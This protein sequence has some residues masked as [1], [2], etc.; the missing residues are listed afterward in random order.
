MHS[1]S[2]YT[3]KGKEINIRLRLAH[4][5]SN[6]WIKNNE[7]YILELPSS[8]ARFTGMSLGVI[9]R[10]M[11]DGA[12]PS[13]AIG[14]RRYVIS[15]ELAHSREER[16]VIDFSQQRDKVKADVDDEH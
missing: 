5:D 9:G 12:L 1:S 13:M 4:G 7:T 3:F 15:P 11:D 10:L 2:N 16:P 6:P 8:F 14:G